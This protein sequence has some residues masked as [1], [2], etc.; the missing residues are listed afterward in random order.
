MLKPRIH[1]YLIC[2]ALALLTPAC[3]NWPFSGRSA[4]EKSLSEIWHMVSIS[5]FNE[6]NRLFAATARAEHLDELAREEARYGEAVTF[7]EV[8]PKTSGNIEQAIRILEDLA[9]NAHSS[10]IA[11]SSLYYLARILEMH[12]AE[13]DPLAAA[14]IYRRLLETH[15]GHPL[16]EHG[17]VNLAQ[18]QLWVVAE[19]RP[20]AE[21]VRALEGLLDQVDRPSSRATLHMVLGDAWLRTGSGEAEAFSHYSSVLEWDQLPVITRGDML[22]LVG[23]LGKQLKHYDRSIAAFES[24]I[25][26]NPYSSRI[27]LVRRA[28]EE[29]RRLRTV[30]VASVGKEGTP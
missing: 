15:R 8:Q 16:A 26:E 7:L 9:E 1:L 17:A 23:N 19:G 10:E 6:A 20:D 11:A 5:R 18:I 22:C 25:E 28:L 3:G 13:R 30:A 21:Q 24:F 27:T 14:E 4:E 29:A 2:F 12:A